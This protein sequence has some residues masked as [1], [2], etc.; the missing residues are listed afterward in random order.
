M[1]DDEK[2][3]RLYETAEKGLKNGENKEDK[4][5]DRGN[6]HQYLME[7]HSETFAYA[8]LMLRAENRHGFFVGK[9][10]RLIIVQF[11]GM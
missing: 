10:R 9:H 7:M 6:Y 2:M 1:F 5:L 8:A 3:N 4:L 11:L